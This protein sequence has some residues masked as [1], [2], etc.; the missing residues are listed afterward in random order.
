M[1]QILNIVS[2]ER[3]QHRNITGYFLATNVRLSNNMLSE[4][5]GIPKKLPGFKSTYWD[6]SRV[7]DVLN[8]HYEVYKKYF[9]PAKAKGPEHMARITRQD[10]DEFKALVT[11]PNV[12][13]VEIHAFLEDHPAFL[14]TTAGRGTKVLS[15]VALERRGRRVLRPDFMIRPSGHEPW[16]IVELKRPSTKLVVVGSRNRVRF[17]SE[18]YADIAQLRA[19]R[20]YLES[21]TCRDE[22]K[23]KYGAHVYRPKLM[24]L[25]GNDYGG[26]TSDEVI[27]L[28]SDMPDVEIVTYA[29]IIR[30]L[31]DMLG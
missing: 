18:I 7:Q 4:L 1:G 24:I 11:S 22:V 8:T 17:T 9:G 10:L 2:D 26:L 23:D 29:D 15:Q 3:F 16:T 28:K 21:P 5:R 27:R 19:Y 13:E 31:R 20:D 30:R 6:R 14:V 12:R 25:V